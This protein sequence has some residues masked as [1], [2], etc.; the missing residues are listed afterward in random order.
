MKN[1]LE[2]TGVRFFAAFVVCAYHF[3]PGFGLDSISSTLRPAAMSSVS[4]FFILSG[5]ILSYTYANKIKTIKLSQFFWARFSR[6]S[7]AFIAVMIAMIPIRL[8][9]LMAAPDS[10]R[11]S[12]GLSIDSPILGYTWLANLF[13]VAVFIPMLNPWLY[14]W[15]PPAWSLTAEAVFYVSFPFAIILLRKIKHEISFVWA[16]LIIYLTL[17]L[18]ITV[19]FFVVTNIPLDILPE[20]YKSSL[21][22]DGIAQYT[23]NDMRK[24][25]FAY[26]AYLLPFFHCFEFWIGCSIGYFFLKLADKN[27]LPQKNM[28]NLL[29]LLSILLI[30]L[31]YQVS[32]LTM[33][34]M[35]LGIYAVYT[36]GFM[37]FIFTLAC[38]TTF[39]SRLLSHKWVVT[40]GKSSYALYISHYAGMALYQYLANIGISF[41][42]L[43]YFVA[44]G[45]CVALSLAIY[46]FVEVPGQRWLINFGKTSLK[47]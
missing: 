12:Y 36:P 28:R 30:Y 35:G 14:F 37:L 1:I 9:F 41:P 42:K 22:L 34:A 18:A 40:L 25:I 44:V 17:C 6:L 33:G 15:N 39:A 4:L 32:N 47:L 38:G 21:F 11:L 2:L 31:G 29:L 43:A 8:V 7:P 3:S 16:S 26:F 5:F 27:M 23:E 19:T 24:R 45:L 10:A 46:Y 13:L 20:W